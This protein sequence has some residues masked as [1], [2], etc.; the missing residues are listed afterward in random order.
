MLS[1]IISPFRRG[2]RFRCPLQKIYYG[3]FFKS[4]ESIEDFRDWYD[5]DIRFIGT[6]FADSKGWDDLISDWNRYN[7]NRYA[8]DVKL[9]EKKKNTLHLNET[10]PEH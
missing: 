1:V 4:E 7:N 6:W 2:F 3:P 5:G 9:E 10:L 8:H